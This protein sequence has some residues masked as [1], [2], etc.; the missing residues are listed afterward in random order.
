MWFDTVALFPLVMM[1]IVAL[2]REGKWKTYTL[3]LALSLAANYYI[4]YFT[5][6]F[7]MFMFASAASHYRVQKH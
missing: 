1:G 3:A 6:I 2:C 7:S 5:C 4:G